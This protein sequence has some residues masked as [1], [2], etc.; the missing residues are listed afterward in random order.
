[1]VHSKNFKG[2]NP[3]YLTKKLDV[4]V[5]NPKRRNKQEN[6]L[7]KISHLLDFSHVYNLS[8]LCLLFSYLV[9]SLSFWFLL[10]KSCRPCTFFLPW[11][12]ELAWVSFLFS[13]SPSMSIQQL[14]HVTFIAVWHHNKSAKVTDWTCWNSFCCC[15][16]SFWSWFSRSWFSE[17]ATQSSNK[18]Q[19]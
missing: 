14:N 9:L 2:K 3:G 13:L 7:S 18:A 5:N 8:F 10:T 6:S 1:M 15:Y 17:N 12:S 4:V 19:K 16:T 11:L